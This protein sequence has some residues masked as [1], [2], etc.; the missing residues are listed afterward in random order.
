MVN[1]IVGKLEEFNKYHLDDILNNYIPIL[2]I[3][4]DSASMLKRWVNKLTP[5]IIGGKYILT[6]Y[7]KSLRYLDFKSSLKVME[8]LINHPYIDIAWVVEEVKGNLD[9]VITPCH[10]IILSNHR[11]TDMIKFISN[12][13]EIDPERLDVVKHICNKI[14]WSY[15]IY[16][17]YRTTLLDNKVG[18]TIYKVNSIIQSDIINSPER[19]LYGILS[20]DKKMIKEYYILCRK[21][22]TSWVTDFFISSLQSVLT[23]KEKYLLTHDLKLSDISQK[24]RYKN[25]RMIITNI[26]IG[27][28]YTLLLL[29]R[30]GYGV[31]KFIC[32]DHSPQDYIK[33][34][35]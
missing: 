23:G 5:P 27:R 21:Y 18:L 13:L 32:L 24:K 11:K 3:T 9:D 1:I 22:S 8:D 17:N 16:C 15:K 2:H 30:Q 10:F 12:D 14:K 29:L 28:V 34:L 35:K 31:E 20:Y 26:P 19:I 25:L 33:Y 6:I 4:K 7:D